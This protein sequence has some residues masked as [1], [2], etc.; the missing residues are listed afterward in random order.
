MVGL[1]AP[2]VGSACDRGWEVRFGD[3]VSD[4]CSVS[5]PEPDGFRWAFSWQRWLCD[6]RL[7]RMPEKCPRV[8]VLA[9][10]LGRGKNLPPAEGRAPRGQEPASSGPINP[11]GALSLSTLTQVS[12][13]VTETIT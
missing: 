11:H 8:H 5:A 2:Q 4:G 9:E 7:G 10:P 3:V 6:G 13:V 12:A 1:W